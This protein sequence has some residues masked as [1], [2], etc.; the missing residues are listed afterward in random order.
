MAAPLLYRDVCAGV[1]LLD[2]I[3]AWLACPYV[4]YGRDSAGVDCWGLARQLRRALRGD[5]LPAYDAVAPGDAPAMTMTA[6]QKPRAWLVGEDSKIGMV[7]DDQP[8]MTLVSSHRSGNTRAWL[9]AGRVVKMTPRALARFQSFPDSY[10]LPDRASLACTV[11][12]NAV[13]SLMMRRIVE[14]LI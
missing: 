11:I 2:V 3:H 10:V 4:P 9:S 6:A 5:W 14:Q 8:S 13:A 7:A 1:A 12:G